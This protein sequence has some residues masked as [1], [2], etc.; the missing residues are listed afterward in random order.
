MFVLVPIIMTNYEV[1]KNLDFMIKEMDP[2][3]NRKDQVDRNLREI[4]L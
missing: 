1:K 3:R 2:L 4:T